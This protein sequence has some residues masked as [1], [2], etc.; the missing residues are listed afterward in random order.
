MKSDEFFLKIQ[1]LF[2]ANT[3]SQRMRTRNIG[4]RSK[5]N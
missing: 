3:T 1:L 4:A 5:Q 2:E